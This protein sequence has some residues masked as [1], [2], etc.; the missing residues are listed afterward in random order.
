[1]G[2]IPLHRTFI[3]YHDGR[4]TFE[5]GGDYSLRVEFE[6]LFSEVEGAFVSGAVQ[7]GDIDLNISSETMRQRIREKYL[8]NT[9]V[10]LVLIGERTWQRKHVDWEIGSSI[11]D[12]E[13]NRRSGLL[14]I[15]LPSY[16]GVR[17]PSGRLQKYCPHTIPPRLHDN[18]ERGYATLH[19]WPTRPDEVRSW[20]HDAFVRKD[21][22]QPVNTREH[23]GQNRTGDRWMP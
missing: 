12:T 16:P 9:T 6:R 21:R 5:R 18:V 17:D 20:I 15:F 14:G 19:D 13:A 23:F 4:P 11:R 1:M 3:S 7:D 10:T 2:E 22:V 8:S